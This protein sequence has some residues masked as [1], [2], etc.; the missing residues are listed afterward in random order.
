VY[1]AC[2]A[3]GG[4]EWVVVEQELYPDGK[5]AMQCTQ[6]SLAGLKGLIQ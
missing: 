2:T 4:T 1:A 6:E 3:V 5:S